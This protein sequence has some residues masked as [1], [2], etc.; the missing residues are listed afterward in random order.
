MPIANDSINGVNT[1]PAAQISTWRCMGNPAIGCTA[2]ASFAAVTGTLFF[3]PIGWPQSRTLTQIG[4]YVTTAA[5]ATNI[6]MGLYASNAANTQ[7]T[8][9]PIAN[10]TS[11]SISSATTGSKTFS[12]NGGSGISLTAGLYWMAFTCS[13]SAVGMSIYQTPTNGLQPSYVFGMPALAAGFPL[14]NGWN[15]A[16]VYNATLPAVGALTAETGTAMYGLF[17]RT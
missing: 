12:I 17:L 14:I 9:N 7:P 1:T 5:A 8:G 16:F 13:S 3:I 15:Q 11:G 2:L 4:T 10:T 6:N